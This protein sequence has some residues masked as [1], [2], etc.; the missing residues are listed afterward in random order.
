[1]RL[2]AHCISNV[3]GKIIISLR[4]VDAEISNIAIMFF[5]FLWLTLLDAFCNAGVCIKQHMCSVNLRII[6]IFC[7]PAFMFAIIKLIKGFH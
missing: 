2:T 4:M 6:N 5:I 7:P 1:M 3:N